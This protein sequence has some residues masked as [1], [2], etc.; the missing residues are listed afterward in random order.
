MLPC[1]QVL[2]AAAAAAAGDV[3]LLETYLAHPNCS[4]DD[5]DYDDRTALHLAASEG[6]AE[7]VPTVRVLLAGTKPGLG[8]PSRRI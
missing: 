4:V 6:R 2:H 7:T 3:K 5:G 8:G 1:R